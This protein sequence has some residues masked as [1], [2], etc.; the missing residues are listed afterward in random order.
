MPEARTIPGPASAAPGPAVSIERPAGGPR[1]PGGAVVMTLSLGDAVTVT[2]SG[3][4][5]TL[6]IT[7][8]GAAEEPEPVPALLTLTASL[9]NVPAEHDGSEFTFRVRFNVAPSLSFRVLRDESFAVTGGTVRRALRVDGRND[10]REIHVKPAG[11]GDVTVTLTGGCA[12]GTTGAICTADGRVL[13]NTVTATVQGPPIRAPR[14]RRST[15]PP[16]TWSVTDS[17]SDRR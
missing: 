16:W 9:E 1:S 10:L 7:A 3:R 5:P 12:C 13:S 4:L 6:N 17:S 14:R 11:Y 8:D 2:A 15:E